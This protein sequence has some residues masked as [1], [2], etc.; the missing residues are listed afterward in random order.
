MEGLDLQGRRK[1]FADRAAETLRRRREGT[2]AG[3]DTTN[4]SKP[5]APDEASPSTIESRHEGPTRPETERTPDNTSNED[6][7][8]RQFYQGL[9]DAPG[10]AIQKF[11][12]EN[13]NEVSP[14]LEARLWE[15]MGEPIRG[16]PVVLPLSERPVT[17]DA[18]ATG[19][20]GGSRAGGGG[21]GGGGAEA[22]AGGGETVQP[23]APAGPEGPAWQGRYFEGTANSY[24]NFDPVRYGDVK[25]LDFHEIRNN[26]LYNQLYGKLLNA[27]DPGKALLY[28]R[29]ESGQALT[30]DD[31][32]FLRFAQHELSRVVQ[33]FGI[34]DQRLND[35]SIRQIFV[36]HPELQLLMERNGTA[37]TGKAAREMM[38]HLAVRHQGASD[39]FLSASSALLERGS[40][41]RAKAADAEIAA[42]CKDSGIVR[43]NYE[44]MVVPGD[45][46]ATAEN[47]RRFFEE[48]AT[49]YERWANRIEASGMRSLLGERAPLPMAGSSTHRAER[50]AK[51]AMRAAPLDPKW[52][53]PRSWAT[54]DVHEAR[55][56]MASFFNLAEAPEFKNLYDRYALTGV[57]VPPRIDGPQSYGAAKTEAERIRTTPVEEL[58]SWFNRDKAVYA[59]SRGAAWETL[60]Q[61]ERENFANNVWAPFELG[62]Y[63]GGRLLALFSI[64]GQAIRRLL[65]NERRKEI[66]VN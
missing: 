34:L 29:V 62:P 20:A 6:L 53:S 60:P 9:V 57:P 28:D 17:R 43:E 63:M 65:F 39:R 16:V 22:G 3:A 13:G 23:A 12:D 40:T 38:M 14:E 51:R 58:Q 30:D 59:Q 50:M 55:T 37:P 19:D 27:I 15:H 8:D 44:T 66:N 52:N 2:D 10:G 49:G 47:F 61:D 18:G 24:N 25:V 5:S 35:E 41:E 42:I 11:Y 7:K 54:S 4:E 46:E 31:Q 32:K 36:K 33:R 45:R 56:E 1:A 64:I 21:A 26:P 48:R